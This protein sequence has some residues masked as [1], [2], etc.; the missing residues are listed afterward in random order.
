M[1]QLFVQLNAIAIQTIRRNVLSVRPGHAEPF[2][3]H[4]VKHVHIPQLGK[5][6]AAQLGLY[7]EQTLFAVIELN[8]QHE[9]RQGLDGHGLRIDHS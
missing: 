8:A 5:P 1:N 3:F 6:F 9:V 4:G 7:V 2:R